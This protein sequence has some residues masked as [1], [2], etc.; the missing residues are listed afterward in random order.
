[1]VI[2]K[3]L[4][5]CRVCEEA[6][7]KGGPYERTGLSTFIHEEYWNRSHGD[8]I[9]LQEKFDNVSFAYDGMRVTL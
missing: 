8:Y 1:M 9:T 6:R 2:P 4:C 7:R 3:P 5:Q